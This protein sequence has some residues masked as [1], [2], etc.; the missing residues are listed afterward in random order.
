MYVCM[1]QLQ[2]QLSEA[3]VSFSGAGDDG[4]RDVVVVGCW[5][6]LRLAAWS[7]GIARGPCAP[8]SKISFHV[9]YS[10]FKN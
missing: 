1:F 8:S 4:R 3:V 7:S 9:S 10:T 6:R 2:Q 5:T